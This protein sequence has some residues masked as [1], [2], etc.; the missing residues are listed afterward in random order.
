[1][2]LSYSRTDQRYDRARPGAEVGDRPSRDPDV[3]AFGADTRV[4]NGGRPKRL[5][6]AATLGEWTAKSLTSSGDPPGKGGSAA[7]R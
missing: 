7:H 5:T 1:M 6:E 3:E 2:P 4:Q